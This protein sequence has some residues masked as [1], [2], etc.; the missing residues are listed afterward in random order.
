MEYKQDK[1]VSR[2]YEY[3]E[4][5]EFATRDEALEAVTKEKQNIGTILSIHNL[6]KIE[7]REIKELNN[8]FQLEVTI[9]IPILFQ[10]KE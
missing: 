5:K 7:T 10:K 3:G 4:G 8:A 6:Y 9:K 2:L 1:Q